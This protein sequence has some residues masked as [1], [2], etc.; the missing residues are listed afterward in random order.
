MIFG[1]D[2]AVTTEGHSVS[3]SCQSQGDPVPELLFQ[4]VGHPDPFKPGLTV[5]I[6]SKLD[7]NNV[8]FNV[9]NT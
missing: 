7:D 4:K 2:D 6:L 8:K 3:L 5:R 9:H 1:L